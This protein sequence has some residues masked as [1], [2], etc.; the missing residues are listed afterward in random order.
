[1]GSHQMAE[2]D[3]SGGTLY[4]GFIAQ[5]LEV[6]EGRRASLEQ[7]GMSVISTSGAL[8]T[9]LFGLAAFVTE[10]KGFALPGAARTLLFVALAFFLVAAVLAIATNA[11]LRYLGVRTDDLRRAVEQ[12]WDDSRVEAEQRI[13]ATRVKVLAETKR[14]NNVKGKVLVAAMCAQVFAVLFVALAVG[15]ILR[16]A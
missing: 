15:E 6:E 16:S 5:Q 2:P 12:L 8:V 14:L 9:L 11:P 7:R 13:S 4:A 3:A 10:K 1:M